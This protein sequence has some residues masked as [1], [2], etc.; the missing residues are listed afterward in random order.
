MRFVDRKSD[1]TVG[2]ADSRESVG[3][4]RSALI[5]NIIR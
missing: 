3:Q 4:I 5:S 2:G 1:L